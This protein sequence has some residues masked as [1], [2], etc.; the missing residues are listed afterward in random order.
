MKDQDIR[1]EINNKLRSVGLSN[2]TNP[3]LPEMYPYWYIGVTANPTERKA[4]HG[5]VKNWR[6]WPA[7]N[8]AI[9]RSVEAYFQS[10]GMRGAKGGG[11][12]TTYVY[13]FHY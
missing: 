10:Q 5:D 13:I 3:T 8:E 1:N 9:A 6:S 11:T 7:D 4:G 2:K 12:N